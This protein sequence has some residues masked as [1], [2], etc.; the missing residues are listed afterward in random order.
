MISDKVLIDGTTCLQ[1]IHFDFLFMVL[2]KKVSLM[3]NHFTYWL[4]VNFL[5]FKSMILFNLWLQTYTR[6]IGSRSFQN[7][8]FKGWLS[9]ETMKLWLLVLTKTLFFM[10]LIRD[11]SSITSSWFWPFLTHP[12]TLSSDVIIS[13]THLKHDVIISS[14]PPT[15]L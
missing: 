4:R 5:W 1:D 3:Q 13:Y 15:Y 14:Y 10:T 8:A 9:L 12:P 2:H 7:Y 11:H 6:L